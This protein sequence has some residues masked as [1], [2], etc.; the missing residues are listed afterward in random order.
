MILLA[1]HMDL[2]LAVKMKVF[3]RLDMELQS[4]FE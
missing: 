3:Q 1:Q 2:Y 4:V